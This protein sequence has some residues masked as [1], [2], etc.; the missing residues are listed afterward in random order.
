MFDLSLQKT[1]GILCF[2]ISFIAV[3]VVCVTL[4]DQQFKIEGVECTQQNQVLIFTKTG[5]IMVSI[6]LI[7]LMIGVVLLILPDFAKFN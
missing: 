6:F 1:V 2:I 7:L 4:R 3:V 5:G